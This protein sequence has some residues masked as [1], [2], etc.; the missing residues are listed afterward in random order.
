MI[1]RLGLAAQDLLEAFA[2]RD[3]IARID[4]D[5]AKRR[6]GRGMQN[7]AGPAHSFQHHVEIA[8]L[9]Q[10]RGKDARS[11]VRPVRVQREVS[12]ALRPQRAGM[13]R[14]AVAAQPIASVVV[15]LRRHEVELNVGA[16]IGREAAAHEA[17][18]FGDVAHA[19][20]GSRHKTS[21]RDAQFLQRIE[22]VRDLLSAFAERAELEMVLRIAAHLEV[23][24]DRLDAETAQLIR[25]ADALESMSSCGEPIAP[26]AKITSRS[27]RVRWS[28]PRWRYST[29]AVRRASN[30]TRVEK[31]WV[32][33]FRLRRAAAG[34]RHAT[35]ALQRRPR[36]CVT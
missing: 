8:R 2:A 27:A 20:T 33:I 26:A 16:L 19:G 23:F 35:A 25:P 15:E 13:H 30:E 21:H 5:T 17:A 7:L 12:A 6:E 4:L 24:G 22:I 14:I 9:L 28:A 18:R 36:R 3:R 34:R 32:M 1:D 29:P 11:I 31:A 10:V